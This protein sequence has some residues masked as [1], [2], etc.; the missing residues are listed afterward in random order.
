MSLYYIL[1]YFS[2]FTMNSKVVLWIDIETTGLDAVNDDILEFGVIVTLPNLTEVARG[3]WVI[4]TF[5]EKI[6]NCHP[7]VKKMHTDNGLFAEA[8]KSTETCQDVEVKIMRFLQPYLEDSTRFIVAGNSINFDKKFIKEKMKL[9]NTLLHYR[10]IDMTSISLL[11]Q[12]FNTPL[13]DKIAA[14][15]K[16]GKSKHRVTSDIEDTLDFANLCKKFIFHREQPTTNEIKMETN[17][18]TMD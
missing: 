4:G 7:D 16:K 13:S 14:M 1:V 15:V 3:S 8:L 9:F 12:N 10:V 6:E 17:Q 5:K 11:C 18:V 2:L